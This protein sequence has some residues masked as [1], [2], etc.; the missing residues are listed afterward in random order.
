MRRIGDQME[1]G[2]SLGMSSRVSAK[3]SSIKTQIVKH[4]E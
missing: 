4:H 1:V 2:G 3:V